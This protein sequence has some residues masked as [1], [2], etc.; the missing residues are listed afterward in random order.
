[1]DDHTSAVRPTAPALAGSG[2]R[3]GCRRL[4]SE[5]GAAA[6]WI[7]GRTH[8]FFDYRVRV[9]R[10]DCNPRGY[11]SELAGLRPDLTVAP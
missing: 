10:V 9:T 1:M 4:D 8:T 11:P 6:L 2:A 5:L 3:S 7:H